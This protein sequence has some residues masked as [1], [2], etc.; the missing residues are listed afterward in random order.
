[1][2][3]GPG[4]RHDFFLSRRGSVAAIAQEVADAIGRRAIP[5]DS[6]RFQVYPKDLRALPGHPEPR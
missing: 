3:I 4:E 5:L 2:P 1:M 6:E